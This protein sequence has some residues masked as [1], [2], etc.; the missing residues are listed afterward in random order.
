MKLR[1]S[2]AVLVA[3]TAMSGLIRVSAAQQS[4][5]SPSIAPVPSHGSAEQRALLD[6]YCVTCHNS[7]LKRGGLVLEGVDVANPH[8]SNAIWEKVIR[9]VSTDQMPPPGSPAP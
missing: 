8:A 2:F 5:R 7:R 6:R 1:S 4:P 3:I 9:K